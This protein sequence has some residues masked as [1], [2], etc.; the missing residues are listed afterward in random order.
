M[1]LLKYTL[2]LTERELHDLCWGLLFFIEDKCTSSS[3]VDSIFNIY[4]EEIH[5]LFELV[6]ITP[7]FTFSYENLRNRII[8]LIEEI[9]TG[10]EQI[11]EPIDEKKIDE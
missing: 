9:N 6:N 7:S 2:E 5:L 11:E 3:N 4:T 8:N 1:E 10:V